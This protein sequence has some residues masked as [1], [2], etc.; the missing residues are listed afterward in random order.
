MSKEL[1][2][3]ILG[4]KY[5]EEIGNKLGDKELAVVNDG[6]Y[7]PRQ[8]FNEKDQEAK[9]LK[10]QLGERDQQLKDL[11][12]KAAG[13]EELQ[14]QLQ[15]L[16]EANKKTTEEWESKA[17]K[18]QLDFALDKALTEAKAKN[19]KAVL[20]LLDMEKI[21]MDGDQ[22]LGLKEQLEGIQKSDAYLFGGEQ[23]PPVGGPTNPPG[24]GGNTPPDIDK[25]IE[26]AQKAG[27]T[28]LAIKLKNQKFFKE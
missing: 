2:Q 18:M 27:D 3:Q 11:E 12:G 14:K 7:I 17:A 1:L 5:T 19:S 8:K 21:K 22:L 23:T 15:E 26:E 25:Q 6:S 20:A 13:N 24:G 4:D 28:M 16:Q 10:K 9:D